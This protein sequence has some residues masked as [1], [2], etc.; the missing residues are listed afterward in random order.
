M[1]IKSG[2][3][4]TIIG[5]MY[6]LNTLGPATSLPD[7]TMSNRWKCSTAI[8]ENPDQCKEVIKSCEKAEHNGLQLGLKV[9]LDESVSGCFVDIHFVVQVKTGTKVT[10]Y[11]QSSAKVFIT[12]QFI[13][14][15]YQ[16]R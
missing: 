11:F 16:I 1:S 13:G 9:D 8:E 12:P 3:S 4:V 2:K 6:Y 5:E 14:S 15:T 10:D 7:S